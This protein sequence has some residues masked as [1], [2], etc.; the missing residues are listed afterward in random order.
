MTETTHARLKQGLVAVLMAGFIGLMT[1]LSLPVIADPNRNK[2]E[3]AG[4]GNSDRDQPGTH[5]ES[6]LAV[7]INA[8]IT[9]GDARELARSHNLVGGKPLPPGIRKKLARGKPLPP[10][11]AKT[12]FPDDFYGQLPQ[13]AGYE[14]QQAGV[15]LVLVAEGTLIIADILQDVFD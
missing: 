10:G 3:K 5:S 8:G 11:I 1:T 7:V 15:D 6:G 13:H 14:W 9:V 2:P 12:R 4:Q